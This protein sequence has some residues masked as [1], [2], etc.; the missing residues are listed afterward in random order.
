MREKPCALS[1]AFRLVPDWFLTRLVFS[2]F[3]DIRG[4]LDNVQ[5]KPT[6]KTYFSREKK[7]MALRIYFAKFCFDVNA[8]FL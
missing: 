5:E 6:R 1:Y 2:W 8:V 3:F 4:N 7:R